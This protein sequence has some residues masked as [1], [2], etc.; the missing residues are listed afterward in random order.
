[1]WQTAAI[2]FG[3]QKV[4]SFEGDASGGTAGVQLSNNQGARLVVVTN[5]GR[6][7]THLLEP[8]STMNSTQGMA[9]LDPA[10]D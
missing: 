3:L 4:M 10:Q 2:C 6:S 1:M 8:M 7:G 9:P 5:D